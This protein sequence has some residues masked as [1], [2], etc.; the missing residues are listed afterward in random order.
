M[1]ATPTTIGKP[2][3]AAPSGVDGRCFSREDIFA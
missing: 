1:R 2:A 3:F